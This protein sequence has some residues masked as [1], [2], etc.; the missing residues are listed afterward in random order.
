LIT[1]IPKKKK[2]AH[3]LVD[4]LGRT[5]LRVDDV[6]QALFLSGK[7]GGKFGVVNLL[8]LLKS[9][10]DG[11]IQL[12]TASATSTSTSASTSASAPTTR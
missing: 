4:E 2:K 12:T 8:L 9:G 1:N 3:Q 6:H 7:L 5:L 11:G 10:G